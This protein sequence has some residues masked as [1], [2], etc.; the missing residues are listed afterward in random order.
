M[1]SAM[2]L[3]IEN[4]RFAPPTPRS[5]ARRAP[6]SRLS[7]TA[8]RRPSPPLPAFAVRPQDLTGVERVEIRNGLGIGLGDGAGRD[9]A[10]AWA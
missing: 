3:L 9:E 2:L 8:T 4:Q 1:K 10:W 6:P 7:K 5:F